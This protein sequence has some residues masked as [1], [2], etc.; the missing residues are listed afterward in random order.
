MGVK[1][2]F[3]EDFQDS[4]FKQAKQLSSDIKRT[5]FAGDFS[6]DDVYQT[7]DKRGIDEAADDFDEFHLFKGLGND[8]LHSASSLAYK[9]LET[10]APLSW[11][12]SC[13]SEE[14]A[15][16]REPFYLSLFPEYF[17]FNY[18]R[19]TVVQLDDTNSSLMNCSP[20][21]QIP[22]G[23]NHQAD[24]P[25]LDPNTIENDTL[26]HNNLIDGDHE[27]IAGTCVISNS[28][29]NSCADVKI[30]QGRG[31]C[32]CFDGGSIRCVRQHVKEA[33]EKLR[34]I[35]GD[36]KFLA[37]GFCD[38]GEEV[39]S[40]WTEE[41]ERVF[42]EVIYSNPV[43]LDKNFW[44]QL[45]V[46]F[47]SR[48]MK[49]LVSYYFNVFMLWRRAVQNR[50]HLLEIDSDDDEW[51]GNYRG[52][53]GVVGEDDED[54]VVESFEDEDDIH[55][56]DEDDEGNGD[57]DDTDDVNGD[58]GASREDASERDDLRGQTLKPQIDK[59]QN[60]F[61]SGCQHSMV[62]QSH[63]KDDHKVQED[64]STS[65]DSQLY[66][67]AS[68]ASFSVR[69][70]TRESTRD[71]F[72][73]CLVGESNGS[74]DGLDSGYLLETSNPKDWDESCSTVLTKG[75]D[76]LPTCNMIEEIFGSCTSKSN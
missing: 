23:P 25:P 20:R 38:M 71:D 69:H 6:S 33:R 14:D 58:A 30:G 41:E 40:K 31:D 73:G 29:S 37:L 11:I 59:L 7:A 66:M 42:H 48:T 52:S 3:E 24:I 50:S 62:N 22:I 27:Q 43:S 28:V 72:I 63:I 54:S 53:F 15:A 47:P 13:S 45:S 12:T 5:S 2:P 74:S 39:A 1:R 34:E 17:E 44:K 19:R 67:E 65:S 8:D 56:D 10:S 16:S 4:S 36:E 57:D 55:D 35:I 21:K 9:E 64:S 60:D 68:C 61:G 26:S 32:G 18:P 70:D 51:H 49:D 76:L 46:V 75:V